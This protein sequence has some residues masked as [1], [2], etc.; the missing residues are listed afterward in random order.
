MFIGIWYIVC[1]DLY[2]LTREQSMYIEYRN[3]PVDSS[4]VKSLFPGS[5]Q[6]G[7]EG[8]SDPSLY[9]LSFLV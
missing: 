6:P 7:L 1:C 3:S 2:I 4:R 9:L 5:I 8:A